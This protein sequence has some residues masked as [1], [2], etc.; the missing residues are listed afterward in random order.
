MLGFQKRR[1][2]VMLAAAFALTACGGDDDDDNDAVTPPVVETPGGG[3]P[4]VVEVPGGGTPPATGTPPTTP[5]D[6]DP[7]TPPVTAP[8]G[9]TP[10]KPS[11]K[12]AFIS[13]VH[14]HDVY[15][16][17]EDGSFAGLP[18]RASNQNATIRTMYAQ[19][20]STRLFNENYFAFRAAL[21]DAVA[22]GVKLI[23]LPGDFSDDGQPVHMRSLKRIMDEY[24]ARHGVEFLATFGNHDPVRP[25]TMAAGKSDFLGV[26]GKT[27]RIYSKGGASEC[28]NYTSSWA[29]KQAAGA[30]LPTVCTEEIQ[31]LGYEPLMA[32]MSLYGSSPQAKYTYWET[33]YS[34]YRTVEGYSLPQAQRE[35]GAD[36]RQYEICR[37]GTGD[38]FKQAD[39]TQCLKTPD[40][41]YLVEPI[42]GVWV[43]AVDSNVY[44]PQANADLAQRTRADN[45]AGS[46]D[47][48]WNRMV[49]HKQHVVAWMQ[50][51]SARAKAQGKTLITTGHY[52]MVQFYKNSNEQIAQIFGESG[53][54]LKRKPTDATTVAAAAT[55]VQL[56][57]AGHLHTNDTAIYN[58]ENYLVNV[59]V[60]SLAAYVPAYKLAEFKAG[61]QVD[62][63]TVV[64]ENVPRFNELF[65]HYATEHA[66]LQSQAGSVL[67]N[68]DALNA[69]SYRE[70][71]SWHIAELT[72]LRFLQNNWPCEMREMV[73]KL[74][75]DQLLMLAVLQTPVT[76]A[77]LQ[78]DG[79]F[80]VDLTTCTV[81]DGPAPSAND[82]ARFIADLDAARVRATQLASAQGL[83]MSD[84]AAVPGIDLATDFHR[85]FNAG[86][87]AYADVQP[88]AG[89][90]R[91][92]NAALG[93]S[94]ATVKVTGGKPA[95]SNAIGTVFQARFK[96]L[97]EA[98]SRV[99]QAP[100]NMKFAVDLNGR[101]VTPVGQQALTLK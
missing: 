5:V 101:T 85:L 84:L 65:E 88:R 11:V 47:A 46:G 17:F 13:D 31:Q 12:V 41:T 61:N 90:Y 51:V 79:G 89:L 75:A 15:G 38:T 62:I 24:A 76:L 67:W 19:L 3:T 9:E 14:F 80:P 32:F 27:Q 28:A 74:T 97:F 59:Q 66:Y 81:A 29:L 99:T 39:Y 34:S 23:V 20:T 63:D 95:D 54:D 44:I 8:G 42:P 77:Q 100:P 4:P 83:A 1:L 49:T 68:K 86:E 60:P 64:L 33:P 57:F 55:G 48:G 2:A 58:G 18:T 10:A 22:K 98:M 45:F 30:D 82:T 93:S 26:G 40:A 43:M 7:T 52:P 25:F 50:D 69:K 73:T 16:Q 92:F 6:P 78:R 87:L 35:S 56:H 71:A 37:E 72:R 96:P 36:T 94:A 91:A 70:F 21:D 53:L